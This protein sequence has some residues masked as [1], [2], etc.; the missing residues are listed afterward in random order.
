M[1]SEAFLHYLWRF[2]LLQSPLHCVTGEPVQII[3]P[4]EY[5]GDG[6][7]DFI[8]ARIRIGGTLWAGC[9]E[10]HL[11][12]SDW[13]RHGHQTDPAYN[14][15]ILHVVDRCDKAV[16]GPGNQPI[17]CLEICGKYPSRL[18]A[19]YQALLGARHWI[20]CQNMLAGAELSLFRLWAPALVF[21]KLYARALTL[22]RWMHASEH[23]WDE[24]AYQMVASA[25]G[26][27]INAQPFELLARATP[28]RILRRHRDQVH[29]LESL[30]FGQAGLLDPSCREN[31]PSELL[32]W[33]HFYRDKYGLNPIEQGIWK[34]LRLRPPNFPTIR[35]SQLADLIHRNESFHEQ[36]E[37]NLS[38]K[39]W[40]G[41][42]Q[43]TASLYWDSHY[44]FERVSA[45]SIKRLGQNAVHLILINGVVPLLF[46]KGIE[47][48]RPGSVE[49]ALSLLDEIPGEKNS[50]TSRWSEL[51]IPSGNALFSQAL[52]HLKQA[53]CDQKR[54]LDC[55]IGTSLLKNHPITK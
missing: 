4:G 47:Q 36:L 41:L 23:S 49:R 37:N 43:A 18:L 42:F 34:F 35:I 1:L 55:R 25:F 16:A 3:H 17:P 53:Y 14:N 51:G 33:Y 21:E 45:E 44:T 28:Y 5:N 29:V 48:E 2:R 7:P 38:L 50:L 52:K 19:T 10:I 9:V 20:P 8:N 11:R 24:L 22:R 54:C 27:Q 30:L 46:F 26:N 15:V 12:A 39:S 6:G 40:N 31:Y 32:R 13:F